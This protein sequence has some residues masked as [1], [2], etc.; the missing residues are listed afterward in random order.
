MLGVPPTMA[1][2]VKSRTA[3][4]WSLRTAGLVPWVPT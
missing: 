4:Y 3:S 1:I 2:G